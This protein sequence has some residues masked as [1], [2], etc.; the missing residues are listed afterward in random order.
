VQNPLGYDNLE[1][2]IISELDLFNLNVNKNKS[3][4]QRDQ[5]YTISYMVQILTCK[6]NDTQKFKTNIAFRVF[7]LF[8]SFIY[9][10]FVILQTAFFIAA[11]R[12]RKQCKPQHGSQVS[13]PQAVVF[14]GRVIC[15]G[16]FC[17]LELVQFYATQLAVTWWFV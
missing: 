16:D 6:M 11:I 9:I 10:Y 12:W 3:I 2:Q 7:I 17:Y 5:F 4:L 13:D 14:T 1:E 15:N 8:F